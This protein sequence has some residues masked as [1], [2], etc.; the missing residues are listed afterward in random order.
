MTAPK[1]PPPEATEDRVACECD[2]P[3]HFLPGNW[4]PKGRIG[5]H[6]YGIRFPLSH[7]KHYRINRAVYRLCPACAGD[8]MAD[9]ILPEDAK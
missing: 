9:R 4:T 7:M 3:A 8:C 6:G 1:A 2:H 5:G